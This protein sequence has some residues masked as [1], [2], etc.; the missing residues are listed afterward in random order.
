MDFSWSTIGFWIL[1]SPCFAA[2]SS[3]QKERHSQVLILGAGMSGI[4][5]AK[6]LHEKHGIDDFVI[7][8]G[9]NR[10]GGRMRQVEFAGTVVE[11][12]ANW[13]QG[14]K[15]N[16][17]WDLVQ[18]YNLRGGFTMAEPTPG[19]YIVRNETGHDVTGLDMHEAFY[20]AVNV[21]DTIINERRQQGKG[22]LSA[23]AGIRLAG[24]QPQNPAQS[25]VEYFYYDFEYAVPP[26]YISCGVKMFTN[27][28]IDSVGDKQYFISDSRGYSYLVDEM[29]QS[30]LAPEDSRLLLNQVVDVIE[31]DEDGVKVSTK[32]RE[33]FTADY[34]LIT[35]SIGVLKS[36]AITF[37]PQLPPQMLEP[38]FKLTMVDYIKI[39]LK[40]P[41]RFWDKKQ[42]IFYASQRR[43]YYPVWQDLEVDGNLPEGVNILFITVTGEE[44]TRVQYQS[45]ND[46]KAE[47]MAIL[48]KVYGSD[49]PEAT[50]IL[51]K[52]WAHDPL[53]Y[54]TYSNDEIGMAHQDYL[55]LQTNVSRMYFAGEGTSELYNGYVHGAYFSGVERADKLAN[56]IRECENVK[57]KYVMLNN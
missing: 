45:D 50:D 6:T 22:D 39:F 31:W 5:A 55:Q 12:G 25:S 4:A 23:R 14:I 47:I 15:N 44:A 9:Y 26:K 56:D 38:I 54:G 42:Y 18:K 37:K 49:I 51:Y 43:G 33:V 16:P 34:L 41:Y 7:L 35:F 48:R 29:A 19:L 1:I 21:L 52:R 17:I 8:E 11:L 27:G 32:T 10:I 24:W 36:N 57:N 53:F 40:F 20:E 30:F 2:N 28:S 3:C 13:V 46:T